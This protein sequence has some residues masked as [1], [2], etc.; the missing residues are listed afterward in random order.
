[1]STR[2]RPLFLFAAG[3]VISSV[4][5]VNGEPVSA[6]TFSS[7]ESAIF[8]AQT[9]QISVEIRLARDN[10]NNQTLAESHSRYAE[11]LLSDELVKEISER[12]ERIGNDLHAALADL[13]QS[14]GSDSED[15]IS[16]QVN[17]IEALLGEA[18][19]V[20]VPREQAANATIQAQSFAI[21][22]NAALDHYNKAVPRED[23]R[24]SE[25]SATLEKLTSGGRYKVQVSWSPPEIMAE[26]TN[27]FAIKFIN[28]DTDELLRDVRYAFMFMPADDPETMIIHRGGQSASQGEDTQSFEFKE[29]RVGQNTL[30][31]SEIYNTDEYVDFPIDVL[32]QADGVTDQV[33]ATSTV[34]SMADYQSAQR[35]AGRLQELFADLRQSAPEG[36][37]EFVSGIDTGLEQLKSGVDDK[38]SIYDV[39]IIVHGQIH[40]NLMNTFNLQIVPEFPLP[41]LMV[42]SSLAAIVLMTRLLKGL[43]LRG[44]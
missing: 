2:F 18:E 32:P 5:F 14:L 21:L 6:H 20:R 28:P 15:Q 10:L 37:E 35:L 36:T 9:E 22:V 25:S 27:T 38:A 12:N 17:E 34:V 19:S 40:P 23:V 43:P 11:E 44:T 31:I 29:R 1:M 16:Q 41:M 33:D 8:L 42:F 26:R 13:T 3:L 7:E 4:F 24:D 39:E 30:R